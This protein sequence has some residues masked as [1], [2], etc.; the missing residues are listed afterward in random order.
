MSTTINT[1]ESGN[2]WVA[3]SPSGWSRKGKAISVEV[4]QDENLTERKKEPLSDWAM[5]R[6]KE[7]RRL[8]A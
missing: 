3:S 6:L 7:L 4:K 2:S 5:Q 1:G 8:E